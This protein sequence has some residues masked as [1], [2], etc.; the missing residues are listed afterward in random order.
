[1]PFN[2]VKICPRAPGVSH[3][4]FADDML[5]FFKAEQP[6]A[7]FIHEVIGIYAQA[8]GQLIN[9]HKCS[10]QFGTSCPLEVP[11]EVRQII[12]VHGTEFE[13]KY[14]GLPTRENL[15]ISQRGSPSVSCSQAGKETMNKATA[16][17]IPTYIMGVFK[18]PFLVCDDLTRLVRNFWWGSKKG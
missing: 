17:A 7:T 14:L 9:P 10:I 8:T 18:F 13:A 4:L 11:Q 2:L 12:H 6:Q 5:L 1:M 16:Q 3:I 15:R